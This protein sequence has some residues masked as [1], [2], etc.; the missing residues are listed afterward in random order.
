MIV[1]MNFCRLIVLLAGV[2]QGV[3]ADIELMVSNDGIESV[4]TYD[5]IVD[6]VHEARNYPDAVAKTITLHSGRYFLKEP[7]YLDERDNHLT[8]TAAPHAKV[9]LVGGQQ[10]GGWR[11][12]GKFW[13]ADV[14][15]V[16]SRQWDFRML[17]VNGRNAPRARYPEEGRLQ[18]ESVFSPRWLSTEAGGWEREPTD[19]ELTVMHY[20]ALDLDPRLNPDNAELTVYHMWD[21]TL[22]GVK[23]IDR[24]HHTIVFSGPAGHPPGGFGIKDYVVWNVLH[25]MTRPGQWVLDRTHGRVVYWPLPDENIAAMEAVAPVMDTLIR[26]EGRQAPARDITLRGLTLSA[27]NTPLIIGGFGAKKFDGAVSV[28][29]SRNCRFE[30]LEITGVAGWGLKLVGDGLTVKGCRIHHVGA[31]GINACSTGAEDAVIENNEIHEIGLI[32]P[33]AIALCVGATDPNDRVEWA[34]SQRSQGVMIRHNEIHDTPYTGMSCGGTGHVIENNLIYRTMKEL[35]DG[36]G[37]YVTFCKDLVLRSNLVRDIG[38]AS[39]SGSS[40]YYLDER[41]DNTLV[42]NNISIGVPP[43]DSLPHGGKQHLS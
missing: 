30:D 20:R 28:R 29:K 22:V 17:L 25:G 19:A 13:V 7:L 18:H 8:I 43:S 2:A 24:D 39:H 21:E 27:A 12:E 6:A 15:A 41:T 5:C 9:D 34:I 23:T 35:A 26:I 32:Y 10:I 36:S 40:A 31:G 14:P 11:P 37:I 3:G 38:E 4:Q 16:D 33:S 42:E 1:R